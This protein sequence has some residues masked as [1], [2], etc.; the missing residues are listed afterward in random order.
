MPLSSVPDAPTCAFRVA[1]LDLD[2]SWNPEL[3]DAV[4]DLMHY[5]TGEMRARLF[6][7]AANAYE[8]PDCISEA[9]WGPD[10]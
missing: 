7:A 9:A 4:L 5:A 10:A 1:L 3:G 8:A 2:P 6:A